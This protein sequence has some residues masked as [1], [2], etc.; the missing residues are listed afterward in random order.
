MTPPQA[1]SHWL[2][3]ASGMPVFYVPP[4]ARPQNP[5][6]NKAIKAVIVLMEIFGVNSHIQSVCQRL[7]AEG[8]AAYAPNYYYRS[9][10]ALSLGYTEADVSE[11][12][13]HKA[14]VRSSELLNDLQETIAL[15]KT[16][17][18]S[19]IDIG[20]LGFCFGGQCAYLAA[21]LPEI[22]QT[23]CFYG[24]GIPSPQPD[25]SPSVL[26][27]TKKIT[28]KLLCL[29][30]ENDPLI[31]PEDIRQIETALQ[32]AH[33]PHEIVVYPGVGHGFFCDQ[34]DDFNLHAAKDAWA[35]TLNT[36]KTKE[37]T[38]R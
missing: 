5:T 37:P 14:L 7:A 22:Q 12:R 8:F 23:I 38:I 18:P 13:K 29:F 24:G 15:I 21:T 20:C 17:A 25:G 32:S 36:F 4:S 28:G 1:Q 30:G 34:R 11:G 27:F 31:P 9:S 10:P 35:R 2:T 26:S 19:S 3:T 16:E 33:I 6:D